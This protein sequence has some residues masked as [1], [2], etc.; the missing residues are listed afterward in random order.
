LRPFGR[1]TTVYFVGGE[2]VTWS[3]S[4]SEGVAVD[5]EELHVILADHHARLIR[6]WRELSTD[7]WD[8]PSRNAGWSV[9][10]TVRHVADCIELG[11]AA[12]DGDDD[13]ASLEQFDPRSTPDEWLEGSSDETPEATIERFDVAARRFREGVRARL[14]RH[15]DAR[16]TTVYGEAHWTMNVAHLLWDSW[17]HE[18]DVLLPLGIE[19]RSPASEERLVG[20]YGVFMS[21]VPSMLFDQEMVATVE[22]VGHHRSTLSLSFDGQE[23]ICEEKIGA[24][25]GATGEH[26]LAIDALA[27][28]GRAVDAALPGAPPAMGLL[29]TYF[30]S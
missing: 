27:G 15:D 22:L 23:I 19:Q 28:R 6:G 2:T 13:M 7:Q 14:G 20:L 26:G 16:A 12:A 24:A 30:N 9:H 8:C 29:A 1:L 3:V 18:R 17:I 11:A 4:T 21:A 10:E 25:V 5:A